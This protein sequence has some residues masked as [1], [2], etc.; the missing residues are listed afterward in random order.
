MYNLS[1]AY[2]VIGS[3]YMS[4]VWH[5][6]YAVAESNSERTFLTNELSDTL[7]CYTFTLVLQGSLLLES[8]GHTLS[9]KANDLYI[10]LPGFPVRIQSASADY[11]S[12]VL[13]VDEQATYETSAFRDLTRASFYPL[14]QYGI[15]KLSLQPA[16]ARRLE[17]DIRALDNRIQYLRFSTTKFLKNSILYFCWT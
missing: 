15:P 16:D 12:I 11:R 14:I 8:S 17:L 5:G 3:H 2:R 1:E 9:F 10:Y 6:R 7:S 4:E 13:L